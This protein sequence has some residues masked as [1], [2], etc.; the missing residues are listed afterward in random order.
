MFVIAILASHWLDFRFP[1]TRP[2]GLWDAIGPMGCYFP[3]GSVDWPMPAGSVDWPISATHTHTQTLHY[4]TRPR[5][6]YSNMILQVTAFCE[7]IALA[8]NGT[9]C[10]DHCLLILSGVGGRVAIM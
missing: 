8:Q 5:L 9:Q 4:Y 6:H 3:A 2:A 7:T 10:T 1:F